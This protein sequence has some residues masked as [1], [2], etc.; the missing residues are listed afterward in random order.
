MQ[1]PSAT[2]LYLLLILG[3]VIAAVLRHLLSAP[4]GRVPTDDEARDRRSEAAGRLTSSTAC[5]AD[6][7]NC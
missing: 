6:R 2:T 5:A 1:L 7:G 4:R 3:V